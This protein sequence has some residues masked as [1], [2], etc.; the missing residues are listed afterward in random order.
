MGYS[1]WTRTVQFRTFA[2]SLPDVISGVHN[3]EG[4]EEA[5][6]KLQQELVMSKGTCVSLD[7]SQCYDRLRISLTTSYLAQIGWPQEVVKALQQIWPIIRHLEFDKHVHPEVLTGCGVPQGCPFA[8]MALACVMSS[9]HKMVDEILQT[10]F[11]YSWQATQQACTR[12]Y[13]DDRSFIDSNYQRCLDRATAWRQWSDNA[14]LLENVS[15]AQALTKQHAMKTCLASDR[16]DWFRDKTMQVLGASSRACPAQNTDVENDRISAALK[17]AKLLGNLPVPFQRKLMLYKTFL[18]PQAMYGWISRFPTVAS[19]NSLFNSLTRMTKT[20]RMASPLI[21]SVLYGGNI[22]AHPV[23]ATQ[24]LRRFGRMRL[25]GTLAW[26]NQSGTPTAAL[27]K[28]MKQLGWVETA[29]WRWK[30]ASHSI[31]LRYQLARKWTCKLIR[32]DRFG[33]KAC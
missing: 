4:G 21:R 22:H 9:A 13:M 8:P 3:H 12:I 1:A 24:M 19:A 15:K 11:G 20:N 6:S 2:A 16:P 27:R 10:D 31:L 7:Y 18:L 29:A 26:S 25:R 33:G 32:S 23:V 30:L 28:W 17:R 14:G 5:A